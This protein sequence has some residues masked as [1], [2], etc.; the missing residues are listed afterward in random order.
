MLCLSP[1]PLHLTSSEEFKAV[2]LHS[3]R[4]LNTSSIFQK[5]LETCSG[6]SSADPWCDFFNGCLFL[7]FSLCLI[8]FAGKEPG[9]HVLLWPFWS[10]KHIHT[11]RCS[12]LLY[13][14][15]IR[16]TAPQEGS[17][18][19]TTSH[20]PFLLQLLIFIISKSSRFMSF[21]F[22]PL[23]KLSCSVI[24]LKTSKN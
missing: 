24:A 17:E 5:P 11:Q 4:M 21:T 6:S 20:F 3:V 2:A 23:I 13:H 22:F 18:H 15:L 12:F 16:Y 14:V 7:C 8:V 10:Q 9:R 1:P 19:F